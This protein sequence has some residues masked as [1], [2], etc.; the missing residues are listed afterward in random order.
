M[1]TTLS[2]R[3]HP[4]D[5]QDM[6]VFEDTLER[7]ENLAGQTFQDGSDELGTFQM[8]LFEH[9]GVPFIVSR[10]LDLS[11]SHARF[12]LC[13]DPSQAPCPGERVHAVIEAL[14]IPVG[15]IVWRNP[16]WLHASPPTSDVV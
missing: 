3:P 14:R 15:A 4:L 10:Y 13:L 16:K 2:T 7:L 9:N 1:L 12:T 8:W 6:L 5:F 11:E